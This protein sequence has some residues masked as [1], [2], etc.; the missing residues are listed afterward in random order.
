MIIFS[1]AFILKL[2]EVILPWFINKDEI[3]YEFIF[4]SHNKY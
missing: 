4:F 3:I 2:A 1:I